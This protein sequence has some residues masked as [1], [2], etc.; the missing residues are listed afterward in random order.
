MGKNQIN[1][2]YSVEKNTNDKYYLVHFLID[3]GGDMP[4]IGGVT[5][6]CQ[7][8]ETKEGRIYTRNDKFFL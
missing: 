5:N 4:L 2:F 8:N 7:P 1:L 3:Y 6:I